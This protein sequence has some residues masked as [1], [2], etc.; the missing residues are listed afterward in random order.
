MNVFSNLCGFH[1]LSRKN[2]LNAGIPLKIRLK[3]PK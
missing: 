2:Y 1:S 3:L